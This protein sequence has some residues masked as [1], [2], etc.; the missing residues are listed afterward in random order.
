MIFF[1]FMLIEGF[2]N[3]FCVIIAVCS[4][5]ILP[6]TM[7]LWLTICSIKYLF[8]LFSEALNCADILTPKNSYTA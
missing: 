7:I 6:D 8:H 3:F 1:I 4:I 5:H 2:I